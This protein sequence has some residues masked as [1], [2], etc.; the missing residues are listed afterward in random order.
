M[1][2]S[3]PFSVNIALIESGRPVWGVV[4]NPLEDTVYY[5]KGASGGYKIHGNG[6]P[7]KLVPAL[8][9]LDSDKTIAVSGSTHLP[10][11]ITEYIEKTTKHY[12]L[13]FTDSTSALWMLTAGQAAM[14][15][16]LGPTMEWETAAAHAIARSLGKRFYDYKT[17]NDL[18]YN[19]TSLINTSFIVE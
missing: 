15:I 2:R 18:A 16:S 14:Y 1:N 6:E 4:C 13:V 3:G 11:E 19:K 5:A 12:R 17:G 9:P 8:L 7:E 10:E